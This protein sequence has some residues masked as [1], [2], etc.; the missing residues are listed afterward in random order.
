[1]GC[2]LARVVRVD[3]IIVDWRNV[4]VEWR[5]ASHLGRFEIIHHVVKQGL[6][7]GLLSQRESIF[8]QCNGQPQNSPL[9]KIAPKLLR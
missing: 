8:F 9:G 7:D 3:N 2:R 1:M 5:N 4:F 6:C